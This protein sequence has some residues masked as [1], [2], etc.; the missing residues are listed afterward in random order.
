MKKLYSVDKLFPLA[1]ALT[2]FAVA[3]VAPAFAQP[4]GSWSAGISSR[5]SRPYVSAPSPND[6]GFGAY[7]QAPA[8]FN[9]FSG[10]KVS[11]VGSVNRWP[12]EHQPVN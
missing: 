2:A 12:W 11:S 3:G 6:A 5:N 10:F 9:H 7:A 8:T 1:F 4:A